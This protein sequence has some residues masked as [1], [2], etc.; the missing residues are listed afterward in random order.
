MCACVLWQNTLLISCNV[1]LLFLFLPDHKGLKFSHW[2][3]LGERSSSM[4]VVMRVGRVSSGREQ[5]SGPSPRSAL[6]SGLGAASEILWLQ[7]TEDCSMTHH[8]TL[9][10]HCPMTY[11]WR[12]EISY[13]RQMFSLRQ[14]TDT[15][16][17]PVAVVQAF[18]C[19]GLQK[20][21]RL[22]V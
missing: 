1:S 18:C 11:L 14:I 9:Q 17:R 12:S 8:L 13:Q 2:H 19:S 6:G 16:F 20:M 22:I 3:R 10:P 5:A 4:N 7:T 21:L 15:I